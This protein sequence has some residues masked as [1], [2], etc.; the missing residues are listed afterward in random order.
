MRDAK[1]LFHNNAA[2]GAAS[3]VVDANSSQ[4]GIGSKCKISVTLKTPG[5]TALTLTITSAKDE[6]MTAPATDA[7]ITV[8]A[9]EVARGGVVYSDY[10]PEHSQRFLKLATAGAT[11]AAGL[12]A[13]LDYG[14][15]SGNMAAK[16]YNV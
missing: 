4:P 3:A 13:G 2:I 9:A 15:R 11:G 6:A 5:T 12:T 7:V 16:S 10:I 8:P 1:L 14:L